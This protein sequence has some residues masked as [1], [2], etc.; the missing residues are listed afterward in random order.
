MDEVPLI[1]NLPLSDYFTKLAEDSLYPSAGSS[2]AMTAAHAAALFAMFCRVNLRK[3]EESRADLPGNGEGA[4][5][6]V[7]FWKGMLK[8]ALALTKRSFALAQEDGFAIRDFME[9]NP[10]GP[11][12]MIEV[13]LK[14]ARCAAEIA[15]AI[16][17]AFPE[18][19]PP[20]RAD[21]ET[22]RCLAEGSKKAA[23]A[24][25]RYNLPLLPDAADRLT[26][27]N[28]IEELE[29]EG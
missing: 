22:A 28:Q 20:V 6:K 10:L 7:D 26:Y 12:R 14:I 4:E 23:L 29:K 2:S 11:F 8:K 19:Y 17:R 24:V 9:G 16:H 5:V 1:K 13:P 3:A 25:A 18:S 27:V 15:A 21:A